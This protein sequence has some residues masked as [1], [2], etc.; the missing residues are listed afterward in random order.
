M[1][2]LIL[3]KKKQAGCEPTCF[4]TLHHSLVSP[5][6]VATSVEDLSLDATFM[7]ELTGALLHILTCLSNS[8]KNG[9]IYSLSYGTKRHAVHT[10]FAVCPFPVHPSYS[11]KI[12]ALVGNCIHHITFCPAIFAKPSFHKACRHFDLKVMAFNDFRLCGAK[13]DNSTQANIAAGFFRNNND[14]PALHHFRHNKPIIITHNNL[15]AMRR[16]YQRHVNFPSENNRK[17]ISNPNVFGKE[18]LL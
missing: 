6:D 18:G 9:G 3:H 14:R 11:N 15:P 1:S 7:A 16:I 13:G 2:N 8:A 4:D 12:K 17:N 5:C 10:F